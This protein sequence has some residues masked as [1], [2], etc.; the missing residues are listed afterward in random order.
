MLA[1]AMTVLELR[2]ESLSSSPMFWHSTRHQKPLKNILSRRLWRRNRTW[3]SAG[4]SLRASSLVQPV[5][6][7]LGQTFAGVP[8]WLSCMFSLL[9][10]LAPVVASCGQLLGTV[11][12]CL[13]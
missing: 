4:S 11:R 12:L 3:T 5:S 2:L 9:A 7:S 1:D 13:M 10:L 6:S 8:T